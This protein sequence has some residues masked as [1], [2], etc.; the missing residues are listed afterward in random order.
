MSK[1]FS[2]NHKMINSMTYKGSKHFGLPDLSACCL[3]NLLD[4]KSSLLRFGILLL[5]SLGMRHSVLM[6]NTQT[7]MAV[8]QGVQCHRQC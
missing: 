7:D 8:M 3:L 5:L 1:T 6:G 2:L 4:S